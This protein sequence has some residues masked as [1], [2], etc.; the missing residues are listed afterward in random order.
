MGLDTFEIMCDETGAKLLRQPKEIC[1]Q[2][3]FK[4]YETDLPYRVAVC[5][6]GDVFAEKMEKMDLS[7]Y[8]R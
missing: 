6:T 4:E 8:W 3:Y 7:I 2:F 5:S 1:E